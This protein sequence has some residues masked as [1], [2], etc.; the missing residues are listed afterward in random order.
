VRAIWSDRERAVRYAFF[1]GWLLCIPFVIG[2]DRPPFSVFV[3]VGGALFVFAGVALASD[4][5]VAMS[6]LNR[7]YLGRADGRYHRWFGGLTATM[8]VFWLLLGIWLTAS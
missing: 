7:R 1:A 3:V 5:G 8:G 4:G 6:A 2:L